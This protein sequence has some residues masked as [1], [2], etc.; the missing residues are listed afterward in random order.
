MDRSSCDKKRHNFKEEIELK[1][2]DYTWFGHFNL[3]ESTMTADLNQ[4]F[5]LI[6]L[7]FFENS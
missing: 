5:Y 7:A 3:A 6:A 2:L 1:I 4:I